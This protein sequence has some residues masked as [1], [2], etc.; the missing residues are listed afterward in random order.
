MPQRFRVSYENVHLAH[1]SYANIFA[2][3]SV[4]ALGSYAWF[5]GAAILDNTPELHLHHRSIFSWPFHFRASQP[6]ATHLQQIETA[7]N[8]VLG[9]LGD[10]PAVNAVGWDVLLSA[11]SLGMWCIVHGV[12]VDGIIEC[13]IWP[14]HTSSKHG[15]QKDH[16]LKHVS[17]DHAIKDEDGDTALPSP[18]KKP[19]GR[20]KK[21]DKDPSGATKAS[22][23]AAQKAEE[24]VSIATP[25]RRTRKR[26]HQSHDDAEDTE[27]EDYV[28]DRTTA[29]ELEHLDHEED[30]GGAVAEA[31]ALVW[32]LCALGGLGVG[33]AAALG[34]EVVEA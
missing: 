22:S 16:E 2:A 34:S 10:H 33:T 3:I 9:A 17:F 8:R 13:S 32:G 1:R 18:T 26:S 11:I 28:P 30:H 21:V 15:Q 31:G 29:A 25:K 12:D 27:D 24:T 4:F 14:G 5:T 6:E 19:R 20:P 23:K 7:V